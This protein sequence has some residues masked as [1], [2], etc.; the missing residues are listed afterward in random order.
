MLSVF[1]LW[2]VVGEEGSMSNLFYRFF[3]ELV[4]VIYFVSRY[5]VENYVV[6]Y[7]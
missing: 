2:V 3:S 1:L 7:Y 4:K 6:E 5:F